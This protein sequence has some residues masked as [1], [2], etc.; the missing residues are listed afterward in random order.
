MKCHAALSISPRP[1][2][3]AADLAQACTALA[4]NAANAAPGHDAGLPGARSLTPAQRAQLRAFALTRW[5]SGAGAQGDDPVP[6]PLVPTAPAAPAGP[7]APAAPL[8]DGPPLAK[9]ELV[10]LRVR[11][12]ALENLVIALLA[13]AP[14]RQTALVREM[15]SYITPRAGRTPHPMTLRAADEM[16]S[17]AD[18]ADRYPQGPPFERPH[19]PPA[20]AAARRALPK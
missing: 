6:V 14:Q 12:I 15:A 13:D 3:G 7:V 11:V 2:A 17:L 19:A 10:Q 9:A 8:R 18:R 20:R 16:L 1:P 5:H 4:A